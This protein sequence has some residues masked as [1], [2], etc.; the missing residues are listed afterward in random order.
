M[1]PSRID[2][3]RRGE[4]SRMLKEG[5]RWPFEVCVRA[6]AMEEEAYHAMGRPAKTSTSRSQV[7]RNLR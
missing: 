3:G 2:A 4:A 6:A 7:S 1:L 5:T